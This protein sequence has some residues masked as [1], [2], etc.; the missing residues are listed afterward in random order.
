M[1]VMFTQQYTKTEPHTAEQSPP[2]NKQKTK[3]LTL[4]HYCVKV[5]S[6]PPTLCI[7]KTLSIFFLGH[8][9]QNNLNADFLS[10]EYF[11]ATL[12]VNTKEI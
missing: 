10:R 6:H 12:T 5:L 7:A 2:K 3:N 1:G 8:T 11:S 9:L 4:V